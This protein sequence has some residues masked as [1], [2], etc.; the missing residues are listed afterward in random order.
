MWRDS[1]PARG[2]YTTTG[3]AATPGNPP[4]Q[5]AA[6]A[7]DEACAL[8]MKKL[9]RLLPLAV[10]LALAGMALG[11]GAGRDV[12]A[13]PSGTPVELRAV[14]LKPLEFLG[15]ELRFTIQIE[16]QPADWNPFLTR[17]GTEDYRAVIAW[18][19]EQSLWE[20]ADYDSPPATLFARRGGAVEPVL[21]RAHRYDRF[22]A[23][24]IVRQVLAGRPWIELTDLRP[25]D[26]H[27]SEGSMIHAARG[28]ELMAAEHWQL[29]AQSFERALASNLPARAREAL[30]RLQS[31][32]AGHAPAPIE[33]PAKKKHR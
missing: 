24:G 8:L 23:S 17:F 2:P 10:A 12:E 14:A 3:T 18:G 29:A 13:A 28:V 22:E 25:L 33:L 32:C 30:V 19:D 9:Y 1:R 26:E 6:G 27:F 15:R 4:L 21:L 20:Q 31:E 11:D 7:V 16:S 5:P